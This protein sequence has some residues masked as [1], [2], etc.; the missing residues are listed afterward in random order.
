MPLHPNARR[1][2]AAL[3]AAGIEAQVQ[4][5]SDSTR[6]SAEAA[7]ALGVAVG[8]IAKSLV[9]LAD[10]RPLVVIASGSDRVD[11]DALA[12]LM[13]AQK[14]KRAD[15]DAVKSATGFSIGGVSPAGL[16]EGLDV[17]IESG[18]RAFDLIWAAAGTPNAVYPTTFDEL[19]KVTRGRV[20]DVRQTA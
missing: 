19:L 10:G 2:Q 11:T 16:P 8:Q 9:F 13:G 5:L 12:L 18:L 14:V 15:P 4:E 1:V 3:A 7:A 20:A 6:T 17:V